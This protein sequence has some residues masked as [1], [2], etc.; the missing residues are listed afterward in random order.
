M[1]TRTDIV[2]WLYDKET[3]AV[4]NFSKIKRAE[5][6]SELMKDE[7]L[8]GKNETWNTAVSMLEPLYNEMQDM[9]GNSRYFMYTQNQYLET[10]VNWVYRKM[11]HKDETAI[12]DEF[13]KLRLNIKSQRSVK[14]ILE[15]LKACG[16]E[17][18][19]DPI[20]ELGSDIDSSIYTP[21]ISAQIPAEL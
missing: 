4:T 8:L 10:K 2:N 13:K 14:K 11:F 20:E 6:L 18:P 9:N 12:R 7:A 3:Q 5:V 1:P 17:Y 15:Y 16:L 21:Y 19:K